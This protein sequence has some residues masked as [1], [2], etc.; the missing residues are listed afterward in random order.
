MTDTQIL[1]LGFGAVVAAIFAVVGAQLAPPGRGGTVPV[2]VR[3]NWGAGAASA[4][5]ANV[6][7]LLD[8]LGLLGQQAMPTGGRVGGVAIGVLF[9][10]LVAL[11]AYV[12]HGD[13][14]R[15]PR[16]RTTGLA[17]TAAMVVLA[18]VVRVLA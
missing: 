18:L 11:V 13:E 15:G 6:G 17:F 14:P 2:K 3:W 8:S 5:L 16:W 9:A 1:I 10:V 12:L 7:A 4:A